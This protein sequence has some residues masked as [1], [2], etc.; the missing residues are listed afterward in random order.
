MPTV[1]YLIGLGVGPDFFRTGQAQKC[2][3]PDLSGSQPY[4]NS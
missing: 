2:F 1:I 4:R 3:T